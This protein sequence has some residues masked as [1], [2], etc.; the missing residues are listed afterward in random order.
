M[1]LTPGHAHQGWTVGG[2]LAA[3]YPS[4]TPG[5]WHVGLLGYPPR[6]TEEPVP[7]D[8]VAAVLERWGFKLHGQWTHGPAPAHAVN[9]TLANV[10][11]WEER[12]RQRE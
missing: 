5:R 9:P 11:R 1:D 7:A 10:R 12:E 4:T 8:Q 3:I 2:S 6:A